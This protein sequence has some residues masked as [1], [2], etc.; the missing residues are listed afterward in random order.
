MPAFR[1]RILNSFVYLVSAGYVLLC[2]VWQLARSDSYAYQKSP[3]TGLTLNESAAPRP[4]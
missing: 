4:P 2:K 1:S 3:A